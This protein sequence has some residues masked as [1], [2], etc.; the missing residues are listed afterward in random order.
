MAQIAGAEY[1]MRV[2]DPPTDVAAINAIA[3]D[4]ATEIVLFSTAPDSQNEPASTAKMMTALLADEMLPWTDSITIGTVAAG[5]GGSGISL[6]KDDV[7]T[8]QAAVNVMMKPSDNRAATQLGIEMGLRLLIGD[9]EDEGTEE[10]QLARFV[11]RM[12]ERAGELGMS[13]T[14]FQSPSGYDGV[15]GIP[16]SK[17]TARDLAILLR[18]I[19]LNHTALHAPMGPNDLTVTIGGPNQ[20]NETLVQGNPLKND[21]G[22]LIGKTGLTSLAGHVLAFAWEDADGNRIVQVTM[23]S[24]SSEQRIVDA[25]AVK[26]AV[27]E[28][29][30]YVDGVPERIPP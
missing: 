25:R 10:D 22:A 24:P 26:A 27:P 2:P 1:K 17:A 29:W 18:E 11:E 20:R 13:N 30:V 21:E 5:I 16:A 4:V 14:V 9:E 6:V 23:E 8:V 19:L 15:T 28:T 12:T 7:L 3:V